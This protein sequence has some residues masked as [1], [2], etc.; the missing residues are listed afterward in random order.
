L[1]KKK[2]CLII[3]SNK[4]IDENYQIIIKKVIRL[5]SK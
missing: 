1:S 3:D 4:N 2:N 5:I